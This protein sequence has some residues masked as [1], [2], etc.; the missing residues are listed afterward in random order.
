MK[1][2][3]LPFSI[4]NALEGLA[5]SEGMI[6]LDGDTIGIDYQTKD[7]LFGLLRSA[8][9][10]IQLD[11]AD[12]EEIEFRRGI[13]SGKLTIR[14]VRFDFKSR[15][16]TQVPGELRLSIARRHREAGVEFARTVKSKLFDLTLK[17][18]EP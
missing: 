8:V 16:L 11:V 1:K 5:E 15:P 6:F 9:K 2:I 17:Q 7:S 12:I 13:F 3:T 18:F 10:S 14:S 4:P